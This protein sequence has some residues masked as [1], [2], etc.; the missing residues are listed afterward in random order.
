MRLGGYGRAEMSPCSDLDVCLLY[1]GKL[2]EPIKQLNSFLV[3]FL[4]DSGFVVGYGI[5]SIK[6]NKQL[7]KED[8]NAFTSFL[9]ARIVCGDS[10]V[11][12]RMKLFIQELKA[13]PLAKRF[14]EQKVH[15]RF[16]ALPEEQTD[17]FN[18]QPNIKENAGGLR[19]F[20]TALW[21]LM[22]SHDVDSLDEAVAQGLLTPEEQL[23]FA[24]ALEFIWRI[25][26]ELHF[27]AGSAEDLLTFKWQKHVAKA[28][29]YESAHQSNILQF[30]QEYYAAASKLRRFLSIVV[31]ICNFPF[32]TD[33]I[34]RDD[35]SPRGFIIQDG[36]LF[37]GLQ[38]ANWFAHTPARLM[39]IYW[40]C[41]RHQ[42]QLSRYSE[43]LV[44]ANLHLVNDTFRS[45]D[46]V[47]RFFLA[48]CSLPFQAGKALRQAAA[49]GLLPNYI[50]EYGEIR[51]V[52]RY[53][54]FHHYPVDEHTL[55]AV[56]ALGKLPEMEGG[57]VGRCLREA[58]ENLSDPYILVMAI[59]FHDLGK[60]AG[61]IHAAESVIRSR[62]I[63]QRIGLPEEDAERIA[64][65][66]EH[67]MLMN[68]ISQFRDTDDED[69]LEQ[70][71]ETVKTEQRLRALFL[72]SF[73]DLYAV[74]PNVWSEWK[75]AL[76]LQLYLRTVKRL[77]GRVES[78]DEEYWNSPKAVAIREGV[79]SGLQ[80]QV[81]SHLKGLG[82]R[83]F[84]AF[85]PE[86]VAIHLECIAEAQQTGLAVRCSENPMN[87]LSEMVICTRDRHGLFFQIA[88]TFSSQLIDVNSAALFTRPDGFVVDCF[89]VN[90]ARQHRPLTRAQVK[91]VERLLGEVLL[92]GKSIQEYVERSR[93]R[94]FALLQ[95][96]IPVQTRIDFDNHSSRQ[97]TV[98]DIQTGDRTG[99][100]Y[101]ITRAIA[102]ANLDIATARIVTDARR[103]RDSFYVSGV[104]GK[105]IEESEQEAVRR[106]IH[107]AIHPAPVFTETEGGTR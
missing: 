100:L 103:V 7:A 13:G 97:Q 102:E 75:G 57:A 70:F 48:L 36:Q 99:L 104:S 28:F 96:R 72:L 17:I 78:F 105:V 68:N 23:E 16:D 76:L 5:R 81:E 84:M 49:S 94:L 2:D 88:G 18:P 69:I 8:M 54:D 83:Y 92:D 25:R 55:L 64:F 9:E 46:L 6:E 11:F 74:G 80:E 4:W 15:D 62:A 87:G 22:M 20:H 53:E 107:Q 39:E 52:I 101:D 47:R 67:H 56:E 90:D 43:R 41:A 35:D 61:E 66:V 10:T 79:P 34:D 29:D 93:H 30:M 12:A 71:S 82:Q 73:C 98:I 32:P 44:V 3:P 63:C 31:R 60:A 58:L 27:Q 106:M 40:R 89:T 19:D 37:V 21:L 42:V 50:P 95:P 38:D 14:V 91:S 85:G 33:A 86:Q 24:E 59:L 45:S 1:D 26:N 77:L 51:G 65:L